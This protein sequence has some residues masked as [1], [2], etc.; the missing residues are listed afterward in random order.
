MA[1]NKLPAED[2]HVRRIRDVLECKYRSAHPRA[3][4]DAKRSNSVCIHVR[5]I[6]PAFAGKSMFDRDEPVWEVLDTLPDETRAEISMLVLLTPKEAKTSLMNVDFEE[7]T[8]SP[9]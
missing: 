9:F 2:K 6:D 4:V 3:R 8:P 5:I 1:A 7:L